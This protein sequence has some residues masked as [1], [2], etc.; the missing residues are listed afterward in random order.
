MPEYEIMRWDAVIPKNNTFPYP[1][2]YIKPDKNFL[3]YATENKFM[4]LLSISDT[5][6]DYDKREVIGM[7]DSSGYFPD[8]RPYFFNETGYYVIILFTNWI[9]YPLKNGKIK[10]QGVKGQDNIGTPPPRKFEV[11]VPMEFYKE[12]P[13][14][15]SEGKLSSAQLSWMGVSVVVVF[16][17]LVA[18]A[19]KK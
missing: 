18:V 13:L 16:C 15:T 7:V 10:I 2:V 6:M 14:T 8:Y 17:V 9:G 11:P 12:L 4:F 19:M 3:S 1:M 5:G